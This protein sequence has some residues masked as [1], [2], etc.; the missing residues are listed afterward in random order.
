MTLATMSTLLRDAQHRGCAIGAFNAV[1]IESAEAIIGAAEDLGSPVI[2]QVSQNTV[3]YHGGI[4]AIG[5]ACVA[6]AANA[7]V[8]VVVHLD[9]ATSIDLCQ[10][11]R[12]IGFGSV[13]LDASML[14]FEGNVALTREAV[15]WA[16][17][18]GL[19]IEA[20]LGHVAGKAG[21]TAGATLTD[22]A[23]A[24]EFVAATGVDALAVAVGTAH[25]MTEVTAVLDLVRIRALRSAVDVPL[26]LHGSSGLSEE[27]LRAG[28][29]AGISKVNIATELNIAFTGAVRKT[30]ASNPEL[31]DQRRYLGSGRDAVRAAVAR[32]VLVLSAGS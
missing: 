31:H 21:D 16:H 4:D 12:N 1:T 5:S 19:T 10:R 14:P 25:H 11:A 15:L 2:V 6:L 22:P 7:D 13:M 30:L 20:E 3:E 32:K 29:A 18:A 9:H 24:A 23:S 26:V 28:V 17:E 8:P 27:Q